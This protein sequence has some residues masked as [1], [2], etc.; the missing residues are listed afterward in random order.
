M[1]TPSVITPAA[2]FHMSAAVISAGSRVSGN[3]TDKVDPCIEAAL[4]KARP[5][6]MLDRRSTIYM[7]ETPDFAQCGIVNEGYIYRV[8]PI[9]PP[10][11]PFAPAGPAAVDGGLPE[12]DADEA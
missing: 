11:M 8:K 3:G 1:T 2:Y 5:S 6:S 10:R 9:A 12:D 7:R 4:E